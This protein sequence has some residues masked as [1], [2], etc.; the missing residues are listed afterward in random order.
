MLVGFSIRLPTMRYGLNVRE[1]VY[2]MSFRG[3]LG[4]DALDEE[5]SV[6]SGSPNDVGDFKR[7]ITFYK[8]GVHYIKLHS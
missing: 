8:K 2:I 1:G 4:S 3:E 7:K 5:R 6:E